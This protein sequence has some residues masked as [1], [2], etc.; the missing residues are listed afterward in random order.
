VTETEPTRAAVHRSI[1]G[2]M[3]RTAERHA[4]LLAYAIPTI[5]SLIAVQTWFQAGATIATG[6]LAPPVAPAAEYASHWNHLTGGE[7]APTF[8]LVGAPYAAWVDV[9]G[10]LGLGE[11]VA[12]RLWLT[13]LF[14]G[15][16]AAVVF[17]A[18]G[19]TSNPVAAGAAGM[20]ATFNPYRLVVGPDS[21][22]MAAVLVAALLAGLT[23]RAALRPERRPS[24]V[25]FA[26]ASLGLGYVMTNPPHVVLVIA[27]V[28]VCTGIAILIRPGTL[29]RVARFLARATPLALL[30]NLWWIVPALMTVT[31]DS[32][33]ERFTAATVDDWT[34]THERATL[35]N[36]LTLN[37]HWGWTHAE[38]FPY[39]DKL[40]D[41]P[42][43]L[44]LLA[45]PVL[46]IAGILLAWR[47]HRRL[48]IGLTATALVAAWLATGLNGPV[49]EVNRWLYD[50]MPGYWLFREPSKIVLLV[51]LP[52][53]VLA[54]LGLS[55]LLSRQSS[56]RQR[57]LGV[58]LAAA[59]LLYVHP[60]FTGDVVPDE[61]PVLPSAHVRVPDAW[62]NAS[63]TLN[64]EPRAGKVLVLPRSD[65]YQVPTTWG[66]YGASFTQAMIA[67]PVLETR[68][69]GY[70][71]P[72]QV[73]ASLVESIETDLANGRT[74]GITDRLTALGARYI[75]LRR[76][77]DHDFPDRRIVR[78]G[79]LAP[80]LA[81]TPGIQHIRSFGLLELY[82]VGG[83]RANGNEVFA[84][85]PVLYAGTGDAVAPAI[86]TVSGSPG[87][88]AD[89]DSQR[90]IMEAGIRPARLIRLEHEVAR[91]IA[92]KRQGK[93]VR[94]RLADPFRLSVGGRRIEGRGREAV[95]VPAARGTPVIV[96]AGEAVMSARRVS[97]RWLN[98]GLVGLQAGESVN[99]WRRS[100][101]RSIDPPARARVRD[102]NATDDRSPRAVGLRASIVRR[103]GL[104]TIR[105]AAR[106]HAACV[107]IP[108]VAGRL[109]DLYRV[110]FRYR[111]LR[112]GTPQVCLLQLGVG[113]CA[114]LPA[115][116]SGRT[117]KSFTASIR[118]QRRATGLT[119]FV[120]AT[121]TGHAPGTVTEYQAFRL[122]RYS[123]GGSVQPGARMQPLDV[124]P[125]ARALAFVSAPLPP[126]LDL[127]QAGPVGDCQRLD[128]RTTTQ[129]GLEARVIRDSDA[130]ALQLSAR[131]HSACVDFAI[132]PI[133]QGARAYRVRFEYRSLSGQTP[134]VCLWQQGP[135]RCAS[136]PP[137]RLKQAWQAVD[138]TVALDPDVQALRLFLYA[139]GAGDESTV[140]EYR[141]LHV[142]PVGSVALV[143]I[144]TRRPLP[145][146]VAT[147][148]DPWK[149]Q[150]RVENAQSPFLLATGEAFAP[151]W[152]AS[153]EGHPDS[154]L[155]HVEVN[156]YAN[157]WLVPFKGSYEMTLEYGP[158]RYAQAARVFSVVGLLFVLA[159]VGLR[160]LRA[161]DVKWH[162]R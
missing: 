32:F 85:T 2:R 122:E 35:A 7:G 117:W 76:D 123:R 83:A 161:I 47:T 34:W 96:T 142:G 78:P 55:F 54:G 105:L 40:D 20:L 126:E 1:L 106:A 73:V 31:A 116:E 91:R 107:G 82:G 48:V 143:G 129:V 162:T 58:G 86:E 59:A 39:A 115:L 77:I 11:D 88:V 148:T 109:P 45:L 108:L 4:V 70:F 27:W 30:V 44:F 154:E 157:G 97:R 69:G 8:D 72:P 36:A 17:L 65:E 146:I 134:R 141:G 149:F 53:A 38:Y 125:K 21:I 22:P 130:P 102:C 147:R 25:V 16:A 120:Y 63:A 135:D 95:R 6:D 133:E 80:T 28:A 156:G 64:A 67:R 159:W 9:W 81:R 145:R 112:G 46:A 155:R 51:A 18:F 127:G 14:A 75:L 93:T 92:V 121:G 104:R 150:V 89:R 119:L 113:R 43:D 33:N 10:S 37:T 137:L 19:F 29:G 49:P 124:S 50:T 68:P 111:Q 151:G 87:F 56:T 153:A 94:V 15:S 110:S 66:Y 23:V 131:E 139:D 90:S 57:F 12:Q 158:E 140:V 79:A 26:V 118:P 13:L 103:N 60:L 74:Q 62:E 71:D 99:V 114:S 160:R 5:V 100:G 98:L 128:A 84:A 24:V 138:E 132:G 41:S 136:L 61:R 152:K 52:L 144:P 101:A 3:R 42:Y